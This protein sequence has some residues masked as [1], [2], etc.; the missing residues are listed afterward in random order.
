MGIKLNE[1]YLELSSKILCQ[2]TQADVRGIGLG[3]DNDGLALSVPLDCL[4]T[5]VT[6]KVW[7]GC[8]SI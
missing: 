8:V 2:R 5:E 7:V 3:R 1:P 6:R 4:I